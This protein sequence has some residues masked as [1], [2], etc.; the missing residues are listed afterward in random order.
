MHMLIKSDHD[1]ANYGRILTKY[2]R[3]FAISDIVGKRVVLQK[4]GK[5]FIGLSPFQNEKTPSFTVNNEDTSF[6]VLIV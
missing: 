5:E 3:R 1:W 2:I 6:S 4:R